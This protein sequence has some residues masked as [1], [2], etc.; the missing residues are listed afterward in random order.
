[1]ALAA[2]AVAGAATPAFDLGAL[3]REM[4]GRGVPA[5]QVIVAFAPSPELTAYARRAAGTGT[6]GEQAQALYRALLAEKRT[7]AIAGDPDNSPKARSPK[8][9]AELWRMAESKATDLDRRAGCYELSALYVAMG[10]AVGLDAVG[11]E[12]DQTLDTGQ[13]GHIMAGVR[14]SPEGALAV[15]DLQNESN[16][17]RAA[18]RVLSDLELAAH[19]YNHLAVSA[20]LNGDVPAARRAVDAALRLA[21]EAP[22]FLSNRATVLAAQGQGHL[23]VAEAAAAVELAP[24]VPIYRYA[25]GRVQLEAND[26]GGAYESLTEAVRLR[27]SYGLARRDLGW[28]AL[29]LGRKDEAQRELEKAQRPDVPDAAL[30]LGLMQL[31]LGQ[32]VAA[33]NTARKGLRSKPGD[34][35]LSA[36]VALAKS[37][38]VSP[39]LESDVARLEKV[40]ASVP[41]AVWHGK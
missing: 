22:A 14:T 33:A 31:A 27:P 8:T 32:R 28:A 24:S 1:L 17:S 13:I 34:G 36:L 41:N 19:H 26:P 30:Y 4:R 40:L 18:H 23:A 35:P 38:A 39:E 12:R 6:P 25:L 15:F 37:Q 3:E 2:L 16:V 9:A 29:L 5:E 11:L 20:Y 7:G 10:R 21:P